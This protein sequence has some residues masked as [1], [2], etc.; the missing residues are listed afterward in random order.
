MRSNIL[1]PL[2]ASAATTTG[3]EPRQQTSLC[4]KFAYWSGNG[5]ECLNNLWGDQAATSGSQCTYVDGS[6]SSGV[7]WRTTW[8]WQG[9]PNNVKSYAYCGKILPKGRTISSVSSMKTSTTWSYNTTN[10]RANVAYDVFTAVDP[11][12]ANSGGDYE[13]MVWLARIGDIYPIGKSTTQV[14]LAGHTWDLWIGMNGQMKVYS[15][16]APS[17]ITSFSA[18]LKDFYNYLEKNQSF[19]SKN[20]NLIGRWSPESAM[21]EQRC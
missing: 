14:T 18:D 21:I 3:L 8:T 17:P 16:V 11:N 19:P 5:Y 20:Q 1:F 4:A 2:L 7:K 12:H 13:L 9:G 6:S 10:I 15:F